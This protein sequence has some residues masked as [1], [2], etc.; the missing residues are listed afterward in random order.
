MY[1]VYCVRVQHKSAHF[2]VFGV[3]ADGAPDP[4]FVI[5]LLH[6]PKNVGKMLYCF[7]YIHI[8]VSW[9]YTTLAHNNT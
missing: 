9:S 5:R 3:V 8:Y 2:G 1:I 7:R 4:L 6:P